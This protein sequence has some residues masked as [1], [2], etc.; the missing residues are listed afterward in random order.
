MTQEIVL[1]PLP[2]LHTGVHYS[3]AEH[4]PAGFR[5]RLA[6]AQ[7]SFLF[8]APARSPHESPHFVEAVDFGGGIVHSCRWPV[9]SSPAWVADTD[10]FGYPALCGRH[11]LN[12]DFGRRFREPWPAD[13]DAQIR[14]RLRNMLAAYAHPSCKRIFFRSRH[15]IGDAKNW[16]EELDAGPAAE[17]FLKKAC[18]LYPAQP[19]LAPE[20]VARKWAAPEPLEIVFCGRDYWTKCG[21]LAL[22]V[23][24]RIL[25]DGARARCTYVG[26]VPADERVRYEA[27]LS[28]LT[29]HPSLDRVKVLEVF[30]RSHVLFHPSPY[31]GL[32]TVFLEAAAAGLAVICAKGKGME[33]I[34][35]VFEK[36][37][38]AFVDRDTIR[39]GS[40]AEAFEARLR[41][42]IADPAAAAAMGRLNHERAARGK[43]S[44]AERDRHL[45]AAYEEAL[46]GAAGEP[47]TLRAL[48]DIAGAVPLTMTSE[49]VKAD[50]AAYR[51]AIG[52]KESRLDL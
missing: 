19:A 24:G 32:G 29:F 2:D 23:F 46:R 37:G 10:D 44:L 51:E 43:F 22:G 25:A 40:E 9:L 14:R 49:E 4:P 27:V 28:R 17:A 12:P 47:L 31:E 34:G 18:V 7:H 30:A 3:L 38:A 1:G 16:L 8:E 5:Y 36:G 50:E 48:P 42:L 52:M 13:F 41:S 26:E 35:E 6:N 20:E 45:V 39:L 33:H 15:A 21:S 11:G